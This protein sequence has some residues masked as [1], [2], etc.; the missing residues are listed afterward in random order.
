MIFGQEYLLNMGVNRCGLP[1][2]TLRSCFER[3]CVCLNPSGKASML[4]KEEAEHVRSLHV[5][6]CDDKQTRESEV[7]GE[8][9]GLLDWAGNA[10]H[11]PHQ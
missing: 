10:L 2:A 8:I 6:V 1:V 5:E 3:K 4:G 9:L 7:P 11:P